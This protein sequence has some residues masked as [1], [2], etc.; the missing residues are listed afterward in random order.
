MRF[1]SS[2][3]ATEALKLNRRNIG[4]RYIELFSATE[5]DLDAALRTTA[6]HGGSATA[7][8]AATSAATAVVAAKT[9]SSAGVASAAEDRGTTAALNSTTTTNTTNG[10]A[11]NE[12]SGG[13]SGSGDVRYQGVLRLRG[14]PYTATSADVEEFFRGYDIVGES[15]VFTTTS[16]GRPTGEAYVEFMSEEQAMSAMSRHGERI[17]SRYIEL[18]RGTRADLVNSQK[19]HGAG[20]SHSRK[21]SDERAAAGGATSQGGSGISGAGVDAND[22]SNGRS[23]GGVEG[24]IGSANRD[25]SAVLRLRGLP[26][27]ATEDEIRSFF[28]GFEIVPGRVHKVMR[29]D[30]A[31]GEAYVE[32]SSPEMATAAKETRHKQRM[33]SRYVEVFRASRDDAE[34]IWGVPQAVLPAPPVPMPPTP[35]SLPQPVA[36]SQAYSP[37]PHLQMMGQQMNHHQWAWGMSGMMQTHPGPLGMDHGSMAHFGPID[38]GH[39]GTHMGGIIGWG[40]SSP[41]QAADPLSGAG[42]A[43]NMHAPGMDAMAGLGHHRQDYF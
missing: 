35:L 40:G 3:A 36:T 21:A 9:S 1:A 34:K 22:K 10:G 24:N 38:W 31:T 27:T 33:G 20:T 42:A 6:Q 19:A 30:R 25:G 5:A 8:A 7:A 28:E 12:G 39:L 29:G 43:A 4:H 18:F 2:D 15:T 16:D 26:Y 14:L 17:G 37:A 32:L 23:S 11:R 41:G 13:S